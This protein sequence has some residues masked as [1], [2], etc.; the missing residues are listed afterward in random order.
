[1]L[2]NRD[3]RL[4]LTTALRVFRLRMEEQ[5]MDSRCKYTE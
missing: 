1:M 2:Q 3:N 4:P 5:N